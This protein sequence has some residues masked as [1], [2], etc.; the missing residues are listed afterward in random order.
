M[1][2]EQAASSAI[3]GAEVATGAA[4]PLPAVGGTPAVGDQTEK[5]MKLVAMIVEVV[6]QKLIPQLQRPQE[7]RSRRET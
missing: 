4:D 7:E 5:M 3:P 6:I 2:A 1:V